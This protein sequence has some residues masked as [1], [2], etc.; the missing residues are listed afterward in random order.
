MIGDIC[1]DSLLEFEESL[2]S[3]VVKS[4]TLMLKNAAL[5]VEM[6]KGFSNMPL[7][8]DVFDSKDLENA[9]LE[10]DFSKDEFGTCSICGDRLNNVGEYK[11]CCHRS[12]NDQKFL[13]PLDKA[14]W[15]VFIRNLIDTINSLPCFTKILFLQQGIPAQ[16]R[17]IVWLRL[18]LISL[19][20]LIP[21]ASRLIFDNF[22]HSYSSEISLQISKD[23]NRT[24][25]EV[26][27]FQVSD[28]IN[29]LSTVLNVYANYD[30]E[31][32]YC[33]GLLFLVGAL[34][35]HFKGDGP[36]TF[37]SFVTIMDSEPELHDIFTATSMEATL[38]SWK[39]E[40]C[41][42][43]EE[44]DA[45][46]YHHLKEFVDLEV[47]LY[48][49]WL[50]FVSI[51]TPELSLVER[52]I[53]FCLIEGWK[54]A[55]LKISLGLLISNKSVLMTL[56]P[57]DEEVVYQHMLSD[58]KWGSIVK[59][60]D[61]FFWS[62]AN[63]IADSHFERLATKVKKSVLTKDSASKKMGSLLLNFK[64]LKFNSS[65]H[66]LCSTTSSS[67]S[68]NDYLLPR[69]NLTVSSSSLF[70]FRM[71]KTG[72][73]QESLYSDATSADLE[74]SPEKS[75]CTC[76]NFTAYPNLSS[77]SEKYAS[78]QERNLLLE[79]LLKRAL[80]NLD[81]SS[82]EIGTLKKE[83]MQSLQLEEP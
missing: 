71:N 28:H 50:S 76:G 25:P 67:D 47:F 51:N 74:R 42:I 27:F 37:Y 82:S 68:S 73:E 39:I 6:H 63:E 52:I 72:E 75:L 1:W 64:H 48:Q 19:E 69:S 44:V 9:L 24:F 12:I 62:F 30:A 7:K 59:D 31:L 23:L 81:D 2:K 83:I 34:F 79:D 78:L 5:K 13:S 60:K 43:F 35:Y 65:R 36:L 41:E 61:S 17:S 57:G 58:S 18:F 10:Y 46:L 29:T 40:F 38:C 70:S 56:K 3:S 14:Y 80:K 77:D 16:L 53:D 32:G 15:I 45:E 49:W 55:M 26:S 66:S 21:E 11:E 8:T 4:T 33:Q 22:Q 54:T 20:N